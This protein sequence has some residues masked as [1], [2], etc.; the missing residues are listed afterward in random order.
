[1][2]MNTSRSYKNTGNN[3]GLWVRCA[4]GGGNNYYIRHVGT[5]CLL[6]SQVYPQA[7]EQEEGGG[8]WVHIQY[9]F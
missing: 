3:V 6:A 4:G 1:M 5:M 2:Q 9:I 8:V 7:E